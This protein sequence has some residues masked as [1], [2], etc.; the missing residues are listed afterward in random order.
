MDTNLDP[1]EMNTNLNPVE[2]DTDL[3]PDSNSDRQALDADP[4]K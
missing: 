3:D 2:L 4:A 1:M